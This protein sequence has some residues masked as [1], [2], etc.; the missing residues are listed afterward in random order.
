M[1]SVASRLR[2]VDFY[3]KIPRDLTEATLG[4]AAI[5]LCALLLM[6]FLFG[7]EFAD[8]MTV[9][10]NYQMI[11]DQ[12]SEEMFKVN[13][14]ISFPR[15]SCDL[16]SV[17][18]SDV[19]GEHH[20]NITSNIRKWALDDGMERIGRP[21]K[22]LPA[23]KYGHS[24]HKPNED[25]SLTIV[26]NGNFKEAGKNNM[27]LLTNYYAPWCPWSKK[28]HP[29]WEHAAGI[30]AEKYSAEEVKLAKVDC[31]HKNNK[32]L[33][34]D[35]HI[36]AF[37]SVRVYREGVD[38]KSHGD[39]HHHESYFGDRTADAIVAFVDKVIA[40][41]REKQDVLALPAPAVVSAL[42]NTP[43]V[44]IPEKGK[45]GDKVESGGG[46]GCMADGFVMV[47]KVPGNV[48][49]SAHAS[50][51]SINP[52][53]MDVSHYVHHF[54]FGKPL[55]DEDLGKLN[56]MTK[57]SMHRMDG[58]AYTSTKTNITHDHFL[59][60]L[61]TTFEFGSRSIDTYEFTVNSHHYA[62]HDDMPVARFNYDLSPVQVV[63]R[64]EKKSFS[65]FL[66]A[67]CAIIGGIFTVA[68]IVDALIHHGI[69]ALKKLE[70][71]KQF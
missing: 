71:G 62:D 26:G 51:A 63:V 54:S 10:T 3:R 24:E 5:S 43:G 49:F 69:Q 20:I 66:T 70:I 32:Q 37:P 22:D 4:G 21:L 12:S 38:T 42:D 35:Q 68:G 64:E 45:A 17:D 40:E 30:L 8:Y 39:H 33:C 18:V 15:L 47:K 36:Q 23:P 65:H 57:S 60:V 27:V 1:N 11:V 9:R 19:Y 41:V 25:M 61:T 44:V 13:F 53:L 50:G 46:F 28:L 58:Q 29:E 55:A 7:M 34:L 2:S 52:S 14:N 31:T 16:L 6:V 48:H 67:A 56:D 59:K